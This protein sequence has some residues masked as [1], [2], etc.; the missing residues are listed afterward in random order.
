M[1]FEAFEAYDIKPSDFETIINRKRHAEKLLE[2]PAKVEINAKQLF[3]ALLKKGEAMAQKE[4]W[5]RSFDVKANE[6]IVKMLC[7]YFTG[8]D[9]MK[10]FGLHP[11]KGIWLEGPIGCGKSVIMRLLSCNPSAPFEGQILNPISNFRF[12]SC[13]SIVSL[14][15]GTGVDFNFYARPDRNPSRFFFKTSQEF[16]GWCFDD[17]G[18]EPLGQYKEN[19]MAKV[20]SAIDRAQK[21]N[22]HLFHVTSNLTDEQ[23]GEAY[24]QRLVS[25]KYEMFNVISFPPN[26][27]DL[28]IQKVNTTKPIDL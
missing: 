19:H 20:I 24:G 22:Y 12:V 18:A 26:S 8:D 15:D 13:Q 21:G 10:E 1:N 14:I 17:I 9:K 5:T 16:T 6:R 11:Q 25:R 4:G 7:L 28:R 27:P 23:F 2:T 3:D